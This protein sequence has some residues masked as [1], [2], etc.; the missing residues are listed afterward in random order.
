MT[1]ETEVGSLRQS[2]EL[3]SVNYPAEIHAI[4][5]CRPAALSHDPSLLDTN[6]MGLLVTVR[7]RLTKLTITVTYVRRPSCDGAISALSKG[8][9]TNRQER[10]CR[11]IWPYGAIMKDRPNLLMVNPAPGNTV[12]QTRNI[13]AAY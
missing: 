5:R 4:V 11:T 9:S 2:S 3:S 13:I 12:P 10:S 8:V 6:R 7:R 1:P